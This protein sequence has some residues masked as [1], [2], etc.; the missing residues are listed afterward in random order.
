MALQTADKRSVSPEVLRGK[1]IL[2]TRARSQ[3]VSLVQRIESLGGEVVEFPTIEIRPPESYGPLDQ[4]INQ[5]GS[6]DWLIFTSVNGVEQFLNR[7]ETLGKK[8]ADL[9]GIEVGAIGPETAKRLTA[10]Q[11]QPSL[12]PKQYQAEGILEA[13]I[14]ETVLGKRILIP[15]AA[16]ARDILPE[17]LRQWGARVDVVEAYQTVL[18]QV[19]VSALC[20]LLRDG[21]IDMITFTSSS[22][23]TNFAAMLC[24]QDLPR[25]LSRAVIACIGPITRKTV[26]DLGMRP[27]VV[28]EEFTIPGLVSAMVDYFAGTANQ[29]PDSR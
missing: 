10:A 25:L 23:A 18:P 26:E 20:K 1:R 24:D 17:T 16:K 4:A 21:T 11:I 22:T 14:S 15:R 5:I 29:R 9:A 19:D 6:Y 3:A 8:I 28:S 12:V 13:L 27:E 7:F 2:V